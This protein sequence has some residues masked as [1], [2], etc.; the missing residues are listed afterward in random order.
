MNPSDQQPRTPR[1]AENWAKSVDRLNVT[2]TPT[3]ALHLNVQGRQTLSPL[4]GFGQ[5]WQ[6]TFQATLVGSNHTPAEIVRVWKERFP[7]FQPPENRFFPSVTGVKPGEVVLINAST[8][9]GIMSTGV[10]VMYSDEDSFTLIT[11]QGHPES[12]WVTF[13]A[14]QVDQNIV[15]QVQTL[16]RASD[17]LYEVAF[18][19][20]ASG[21]QDRIWQHVLT[22]LAAHFGAPA[23]VTLTKQC[24]DPRL[25][26]S[27]VGNI[28]HNAQLH[29]LIYTI[30]SRL[31]KLVRGNAT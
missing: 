5:L 30:S 14:S 1:D 18:R 12:G 27:E 8:P 6:K 26:W 10:M 3:G 9:G 22:A 25:Q 2:G 11:P 13:S 7:E 28:R 4:K 31:R 20:I 23:V 19:L 29:T 17:P 16:A 24:V 15:L 21:M